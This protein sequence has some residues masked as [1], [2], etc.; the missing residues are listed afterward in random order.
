MRKIMHWVP[1]MKATAL[2]F[3]MLVTIFMSGV[4][5][6]QQKRTTG[7]AQVNGLKMYYEIHGSG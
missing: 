7:Y 5:S 3:S 2:F 6:G 4:V 1:N